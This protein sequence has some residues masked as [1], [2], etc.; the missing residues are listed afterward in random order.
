MNVTPCNKRNKRNEGFTLVETL[1]AVFLIM[2]SIAIMA[3]FVHKLSQEGAYENLN[4]ALEAVS[5]VEAL[6]KNTPYQ[7]AVQGI[8][9]ETWFYFLPYK[10]CSTNLEN[11][12]YTHL[13][14]FER[15]CKKNAKSL[16]N[17]AVA[18]KAVPVLSTQ[19]KIQDLLVSEAETY[20]FEIKAYGFKPFAHVSFLNKTPI[21]NYTT[22]LKKNMNE[23]KYEQKSN[24]RH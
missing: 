4:N 17:R 16:S 9:K 14:D 23:N 12:V 7:E 24:K 8:K 19:L 1:L 3:T 11:K 21:I 6:L 18:V 15:F 5:E 2:G 20:F 13:G 22:F 10:Y